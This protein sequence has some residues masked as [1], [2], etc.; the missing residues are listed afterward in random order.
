MGNKRKDREANTLMVVQNFA[1]GIGIHSKGGGQM[2]WYR[3]IERRAFYI[4]MIPLH[5]TGLCLTSL[6]D[7]S[8][9]SVSNN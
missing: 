7:G 3:Y 4:P 1:L 5:D 2:S 8:Q 9:S 6:A